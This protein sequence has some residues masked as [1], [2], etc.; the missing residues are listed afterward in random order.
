MVGGEIGVR[1]TSHS[2]HGNAPLTS[3]SCGAPLR[4]MAGRLALRT[5]EDPR[6]QDV[7]S[8]VTR[9]RAF[10]EERT[11]RPIGA[12]KFA[13][14][15]TDGDGAIAGGL[16]G[17]TYWDWSYVDYLWIEEPL[18]KRGWGR[19][20]IDRAEAIAVGRGCRG[21]WL[22]TFSFQAPGFYRRMGYREFG[23]MD[24]H[25]SGASRHFFWKPLPASPQP[26]SAPARRR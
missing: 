13:V 15:V 25:P 3:L 2:P 18:R 16:V 11:G 23:R 21:V 19:K 22:D 24:D 5:D 12:R 9:L 6:P 20:L 26:T 8:I 7:E 17:I 14:Y 10:N 1:P 4:G